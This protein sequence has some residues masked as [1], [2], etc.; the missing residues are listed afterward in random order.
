MD[1]GKS[2]PHSEHQLY[3]RHCVDKK[4]FCPVHPAIMLL[5]KKIINKTISYKSYVLIK[6]VKQNQGFPGG[7]VV[8]T[9]HS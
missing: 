2:F 3:S 4:I 9:L 8:K 6:K 1:T 7:P 5:F